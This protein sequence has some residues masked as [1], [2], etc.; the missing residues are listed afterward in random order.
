VIASGMPAL[1]RVDATGADHLIPSVT[2]L[3]AA[4]V[5]IL[6]TEGKLGSK[7]DWVKAASR[8]PAYQNQRDVTRF[9]LL[10]AAHDSAIDKINPGLTLAGKEGLLP[11]LDLKH[12]RDGACQTVEHIAPSTQSTGWM[13]EIYEDSESI[14]R[15]GNLTLL[16]QSENS[17][18]GNESWPKKR[19]IYQVL[20]A[21]T[22]DELDPLLSSAKAQGIDI[23]KS[24]AELLANSKHLPM[25]KAVAS[26]PGDWTLNLVEQRSIR[27]AEL[28]WKQIAPWL[29]LPT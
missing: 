4:L 11:M 20:S 1:C 9:I 25:V 18:L 16:P 22:S 23:G 7:D 29:D 28:A 6:T 3:K 21:E 15:L 13:K 10:A 2:Q 17:S 26:V 8:I 19:L 12:W 5:H 24:T 14:N 27:I